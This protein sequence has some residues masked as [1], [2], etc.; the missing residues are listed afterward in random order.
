MDLFIKK[1]KKV[2]NKGVT[3][4]HS[5]LQVNIILMDDVIFK[6]NNITS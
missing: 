6:F 5:R 2:G 3:P 4:L 1:K